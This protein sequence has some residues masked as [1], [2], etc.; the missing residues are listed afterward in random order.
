[1]LDPSYV[2]HSRQGELPVLFQVSDHLFCDPVTA[3]KPIPAFLSLRS[4]IWEGRAL[5]M[6]AE[7]RAWPAEQ[8]ED[9]AA[10]PEGHQLLPPLHLHLLLLSPQ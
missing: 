7:C 4:N 8:A 1:M 3:A 9:R 2:S 5:L 6:E 10:S